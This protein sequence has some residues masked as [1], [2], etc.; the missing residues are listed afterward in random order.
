[1]SSITPCQTKVKRFWRRKIRTLWAE[2]L[3]SFFCI[4]QIA[5][6]TK[7]FLS[8]A[9]KYVDEIDPWWQVMDLFYNSKLVKK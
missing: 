3:Q 7:A 6:C 4:Q 1:L 9:H 2:N 5:T 8:S